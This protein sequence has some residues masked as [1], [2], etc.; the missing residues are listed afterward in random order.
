M[1]NDPGSR[2][3]NAISIQNPARLSHSPLLKELSEQFSGHQGIITASPASLTPSPMD[4]T[5]NFLL[6][7]PSFAADVQSLNR[8][9]LCDPMDCS[10]TGF[11]I[12]HYL[13]GFSQNHVHWISDAIHPLSSPS[14]PCLQSFPASGSFSVSQ[15]F[16]SGCGPQPSFLPALS[17]YNTLPT[18]PTLCRLYHITSLSTLLN[19]FQGNCL[20]KWRRQWQPTPILLP[21]KSHGWRSLVGCNPWG[22]YESETTEQL[23]FLLSCTREG[24][25]N[26]LQCSCLENPRD[27]GAW[28]AAIYEVARSRTQLKWLSSSSLFKSL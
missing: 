26:P 20:F 15:L 11:P 19:F 14:P 5:H 18:Q 27:A 6:L 24:N 4:I 17:Y 23:H 3:Y 8:V 28:W 1:W 10:T 12:C 13:L 7:T 21:E 2:E 9:Q 22:C 25:G 16:I